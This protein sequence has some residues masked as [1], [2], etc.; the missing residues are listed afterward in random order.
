MLTRREAIALCLVSPSL[1]LVPMVTRATHGYLNVD[2]AL[3]RGY[4]PAR[5]FLN[6]TE[7]DEVRELNDE[8]GWLI[9]FRTDA[10]GCKY[11]DTKQVDCAATE[12]L[13]GKVTYVPNPNGKP[14]AWE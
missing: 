10:R 11:S 5:V 4:L 6:G 1:A 13:F 12:K 9:R 8:E 3:A 14:G 7:I 2:I